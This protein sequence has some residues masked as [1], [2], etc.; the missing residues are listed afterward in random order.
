MYGSDVGIIDFLVE[1]GADPLAQDDAGRMPL[2]LALVNKREAI[3][4]WYRERFP[5]LE[6]SHLALEAK[7]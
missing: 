3:V 1:R 2:F 4:D 7:E 6:S 5:D